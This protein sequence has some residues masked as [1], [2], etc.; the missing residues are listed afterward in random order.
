MVECLQRTKGNQMDI[1]AIVLPIVRI[2]PWLCFFVA[3]TGPIIAI[4]YLVTE[5]PAIAMQLFFN[6]AVCAAVASALV[7]DQSLRVFGLVVWAI[8]FACWIKVARDV[9]KQRKKL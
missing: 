2:M 5:R 3:F 9:K 7:H 8:L 4:F 6:S 1:D